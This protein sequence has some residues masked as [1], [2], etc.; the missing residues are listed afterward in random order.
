M[1]KNVLTY[2]KINFSLV[3][4]SCKH[5]EQLF[6]IMKLLESSFRVRHKP[7]LFAMCGSKV[8]KNEEGG[9]RKWGVA[10]YGATC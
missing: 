1:F 3:L 6:K 9:R 2:I 10:G 5:G 4:Q 8:D 7:C